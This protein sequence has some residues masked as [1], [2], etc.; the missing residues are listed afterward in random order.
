MEEQDHPIIPKGAD[1]RGYM[2]LEADRAAVTALAKD[3]GVEPEVEEVIAYPE[4]VPNATRWVWTEDSSHPGGIL[5]VYEPGVKA[6]LQLVKDMQA[7]V[8]HLCMNDSTD[9]QTGKRVASFDPSQLND[10]MN[11]SSTVWVEG[12]LVMS[13]LFVIGDPVR[14][15]RIEQREPSFADGPGRRDVEH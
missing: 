12:D 5:C 15:T 9:N 13:G 1:V 10:L 8:F 2:P 14:N 3:H 7:F 6:L 4:I 11:R